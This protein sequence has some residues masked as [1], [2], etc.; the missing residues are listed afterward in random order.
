MWST[1]TNERLRRRFLAIRAEFVR[2]LAHDPP[3]P[4]GALFYC[5]ARQSLPAFKTFLGARDPAFLGA[6]TLEETS[7]GRFLVETTERELVAVLGSDYY[8]VS[9]FTLA[10]GG[11]FTQSIAG[12]WRDLSARYAT[13]CAGVVNALVSHDRAR[14]H[15]QGLEAWTRGD[16]PPGILRALRVF[17]FVE[18]PILVGALARNRGVRVV[19]VYLERS[20]GRF[21]RLPPTPVCARDGW[22]A[23]D[24]TRSAD[25]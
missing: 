2:R 24:E 13:A 8:R 4:N 19:D 21:E 14:I 3:R 7:A 11:A 1:D 15:R 12:I 5:G 18:F 25:A 22:S 9:T 23:A 17:G 20:P 6:R 16:R 10:G